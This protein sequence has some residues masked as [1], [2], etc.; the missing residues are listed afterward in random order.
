MTSRL[1]RLVAAALVTRDVDASDRRRVL[2]RPTV[3]GRAV[4]D[5]YIFEGMAREQQ[6]L[7]ALSLDELGQLNSL[8]RK[9]I[10]SIDV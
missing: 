9:V 2:V 10:V 7:H 1:D 6:L 3:A 5:R 4:W 8:L